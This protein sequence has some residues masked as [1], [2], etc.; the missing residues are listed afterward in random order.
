[1]KVSINYDKRAL[2][3]NPDFGKKFS[4]IHIFLE[5]INGQ[6][7]AKRLKSYGQKPLKWASFKKRPEYLIY[8]CS[9]VSKLKSVFL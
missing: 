4:D 6:N 7:L 5:I 3:Y 1:V 8:I 2:S 9:I